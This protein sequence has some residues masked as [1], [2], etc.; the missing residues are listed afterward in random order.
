MGSLLHLKAY[1]RVE[2]QGGP[3][4]PQRT[5]YSNPR[6]NTVVLRFL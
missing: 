3:E 6:G 2:H 1:K 4:A 5:V